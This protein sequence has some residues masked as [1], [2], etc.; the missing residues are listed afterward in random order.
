MVPLEAVGDHQPDHEA[1]TLKLLKSLKC[2]A[3]L[4]QQDFLVLVLSAVPTWAGM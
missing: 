1:T 3:V 4:S 2:K